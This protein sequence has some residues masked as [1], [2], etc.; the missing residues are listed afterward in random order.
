MI[1]S[2]GNRVSTF[3][4]PH[5]EHVAASLPLLPPP[6]P[7][8]VS[9]LVEQKCL[10]LPGSPRSPKVKHLGDKERKERKEERRKRRRRQKEKK[11]L[12]QFRHGHTFLLPK[13]LNR[14]LLSY[15]GGGGGV[16]ASSSFT[17][18]SCSDFLNGS[19]KGGRGRV[20]S[21]SISWVP[22][23]SV[24]FRWGDQPLIT[25]VVSVLEM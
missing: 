25:G 16:S 19:L 7:R 24:P 21:Q 3:N 5:L 1:Y 9:S 14:F 15:R 11:A 12:A 6:P 13:A 2:A 22:P 17:P 18:F 8:P 10:Q 23:L 4:T 20:G